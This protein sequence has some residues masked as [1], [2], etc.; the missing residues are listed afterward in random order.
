[1]IHERV[2]HARLYLGWSQTQL[3]EMVGVTQPAISQI[4]KSGQVSDETLDA[5]AAV[6][7][8]SPWWFRQG[9]LPDLPMG[10]LRFRKRAGTPARDDERVR[11]NIR[12]ALEIIDRFSAAVE[13]P[14]IRV[15]PVPSTEELDGEAIELKALE[16]REWL[17]VG[18]L[19]PIP[20]VMRAVERAG[21]VV[22]GSALEIERHD[23][24][25][26]WSPDSL[27][28]V[29][30]FSR[31]F[32]G[33]H[34][35]LSMAHEIAHL[36][37]HHLRRVTPA[38]AE[39][40]AFRFAGALLLPST[41]AH[42]ELEEPVTLRS[43]AYVKARWGISIAALIRRCW[44]LGIISDTKRTS[45]EKQLSARGW[46]KAEPV[47]VPDESPLLIAKMIKIAAGTSSPQRLHS[48]MGLP[49]LACKDLV[50]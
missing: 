2:R 10:S 19:D 49:P 23:A 45:L 29:I 37:L 48:L 13:I 15:R 44:D 12:Q 26:F 40:E 3:A 27:R 39:S 47:H 50:A 30:C 9:P 41:V 22:M 21:V 28:P 18:P 4:E 16:V 34:N 14:P 35:R 31:G 25:S 20:S 32:P 33:D 36:V 8:F 5:I 38:Q 1:M 11:A 24:V 42:E 46:R 6:T 43:L 17:G 7:G